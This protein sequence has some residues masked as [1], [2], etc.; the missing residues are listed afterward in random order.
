MEAL[1]LALA[2]DLA[3]TT[4]SPPFDNSA[5]D[6]YAVRSAGRRGRARLPGWWTR[7]RRVVRHAK[8]VGEGEAIKIFTGGRD[9]RRRRRRRDGREHLGLGRGVRTEE[10]ACSRQQPP[11]RG[12]GHAPR[13]TSSCPR[14]P[15]SGPPEI[16]LA[17]T[18]GYGRSPSTAGRSGRPLDRDRA[19]RAGDARPR[20]GRDLRLQLLR[21]RRRGPR[22][23]SRGPPPLRSLRRRRH[24]AFRH[25]KRPWRRPTWS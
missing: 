10:G 15:R 1:G 18:Q 22:G 21:P 5:V 7:R 14:G 6:G 9:P 20:A 3:A 23:R 8:S 25:Q 12:R 13:E 19:R 11:R 17:A 4:D 16:A 24:S 2:R